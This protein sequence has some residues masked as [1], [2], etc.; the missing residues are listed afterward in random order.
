[1]VLLLSQM[2]HLAA[3]GEVVGHQGV[4]AAVALEVDVVVAVIEVVAEVD[5]VVDEA[6]VVA[7][8]V[9]MITTKEVDMAVNRQEDTVVVMG[10]SKVKDTVD[11]LVVVMA[12]L[13]EDM[14]NS[15]LPELEVMVLQ[16]LGVIMQHQQQLL[17]VTSPQLLLLLV[18]VGMMLQAMLKPMQVM[19]VLHKP[20]M[21]R[22]LVTDNKQLLVM[23]NNPLLLLLMV[24][25]QLLAVMV[26]LLLAGMVLP[27]LVGM[28]L[29]LLLQLPARTGSRPMVVALVMVVAISNRCV[30][31]AFFL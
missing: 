29:L 19:E 4:V 28:V 6:V 23:V 8:A 21:V 12:A 16:L 7:V 1:M 17:V 14:D 5:L 31:F 30:T 3:E 25:H 22:L 26:P 13:E 20:V 27:L 11:N 15:L 24:Q 9:V 10:A 2:K 18:M